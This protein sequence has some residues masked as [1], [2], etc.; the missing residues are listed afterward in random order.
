M[1]FSSIIIPNSIPDVF[2]FIDMRAKCGWGRLDEATASKTLSAG[3]SSALCQPWVKNP[4]TKERALFSG[5]MNFM[6]RV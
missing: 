5:L 4:F 2:D 6:A 3:L 1:S